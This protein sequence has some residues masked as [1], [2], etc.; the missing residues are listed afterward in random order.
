MDRCTSRSFGIVIAGLR[1]GHAAYGLCLMIACAIAKVRLVDVLK[2]T[3]IMLVPMLAVLAATIIWPSIALFIPSLFPPGTTLDDHLGTI[4]APVIFSCARP[5]T[6]QLAAV[7]ERA[8][9]RQRLMH[10]LAT[11][12][13]TPRLSAGGV[14]ADVLRA[15]LSSNFMPARSPSSVLGH[16]LDQPQLTSPA[17]I[18]AIS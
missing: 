3:L 18:S 4:F 10:A 15:L 12:V 5:A 17:D 8:G 6:A 14:V 13:G 11:T 9:Q 16:H 7:A 1:P 2:D